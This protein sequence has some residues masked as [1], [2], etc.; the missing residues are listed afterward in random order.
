MSAAPTVHAGRAKTLDELA[1]SLDW[2]PV[3]MLTAFFSYIDPTTGS[4]RYGVVSIQLSTS[5][6]SSRN[7]EQAPN[8]MRIAYVRNMAM[9]VGKEHTM[10]SVFL[11]TSMLSSS[12]DK[13]LAASLPEDVSHIDGIVCAITYRPLV[14]PAI[15]E[16]DER[17]NHSNPNAYTYICAAVV[18]LNAVPAEKRRKNFVKGDLTPNDIPFIGVHVAPGLE[19][20]AKAVL[21]APF[22]SFTNLYVP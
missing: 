12:S 3:R 16:V 6:Q 17:E 5:S 20:D 2:R 13:A 10:R 7:P 22:S 1:D 11:N 21:A 4:K 15:V 18:D 9:P 8:K 19:E 14:D